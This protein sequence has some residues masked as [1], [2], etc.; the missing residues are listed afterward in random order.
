MSRA[1]LRVEALVEGLRRGDRAMLARAITLVEDRRPSR[2]DDAQELLRAVWPHSGSAMRVGFT[3]TPGVGKST[4]IESL[5]M[6]LVEEGRR[7]AV[8]A[9][10]P[11]STVS[12][13]SI[14]GDKA[15]MHRL[16][17]HERAYI[18]PSPTATTLGG[19]ARRTLEAMVICEAARFDVVF[20]ETVGVGQS[21][22]T[23][24][25]LVDTMVL[26]LLPGG[27]DEL[28][29]IK[30]GVLERAHVVV[31]HKADGD[32]ERRARASAD[33]VRAALR[34]ARH[35]EAGPVVVEASSTTGKGLDTL[36]D[37]VRTRNSW[38]ASGD[39][40]R[41]H[42]RDGLARLIH[43]AMADEVTARLEAHPDLPR[44]LEEA[45][46]AVLEGNALPYG[47]AKAILDRL[48]RTTG[49]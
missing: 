43:A 49:H 2:Q 40:L 23:V 28:Q 25:D 4:L 30:R 31:L 21:E 12:G 47:S 18:R 10:D 16:A 22:V 15:R 14:L 38:L 8:L 6:R 39:R 37:A 17:Q 19:V 46:G 35:T 1:Q 33:D 9:I 5:G 36:W 13:G 32:N 29:G 20:I 24:A 34:Y 44:A 26:L 41:S 7:V 45:A 27:G 48:L 42:R 3:G 11:S